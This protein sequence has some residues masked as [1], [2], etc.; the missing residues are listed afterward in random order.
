MC[1]FFLS[2]KSFRLLYEPAHFMAYV[3]SIITQK[4]EEYTNN[5]K[6]NAQR[7]LQTTH[8]TMPYGYA[9][10]NIIWECRNVNQTSLIF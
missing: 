8:S 3:L 6:K 10:Y 1:V 2:L 4:S 9:F 5:A 7:V